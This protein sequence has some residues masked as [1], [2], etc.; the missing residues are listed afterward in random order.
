VRR[1]RAN[2]SAVD[3]GCA[4]GMCALAGIVDGGLRLL[5]VLVIDTA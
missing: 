4:K 3:R 1:R 5:L 2:L